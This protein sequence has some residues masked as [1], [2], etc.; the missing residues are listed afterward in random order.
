MRFFERKRATPAI[1]IVSLIDILIVLLIFRW[2]P[3]PQT[4]SGGQATLPESSQPREGASEASL[5]VTVANEPPSS[6][7]TAHHARCSARLNR[8]RASPANPTGPEHS[9]ATRPRRGVHRRG[10]IFSGRASKA[11]A[12][13]VNAWGQ[14]GLCKNY[15]GLPPT[16][17]GGRDE[18]HGVDPAAVPSNIIGDGP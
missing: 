4:P 18:G 7:R 14:L 12:L 3:R 5:I 10:R 9:A 17:A 15:F 8:P 11:S 2:S 6:G 1:I 16:A 13:Q